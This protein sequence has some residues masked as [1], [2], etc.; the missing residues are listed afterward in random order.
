M[1]RRSASWHHLCQE[2]AG[3]QARS[4]TPATFATRRSRCA[5]PRARGVPASMS[6]ATSVQVLPAPCARTRMRSAAA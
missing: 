3:C 2:R 5:G 1:R 6:H 4:T